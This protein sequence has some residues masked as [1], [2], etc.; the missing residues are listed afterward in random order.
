MKLCILLNDKVNKLD[1][2]VAR[3]FMHLVLYTNLAFELKQVE[4]FDDEQLLHPV[5]H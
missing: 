1:I 3:E 5:K 2:A 4:Q